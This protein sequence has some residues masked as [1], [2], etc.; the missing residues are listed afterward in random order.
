MTRRS[1]LWSGALLCLLGILAM[2]VAATATG[3]APA[4][5]DQAPIDPGLKD[6]LWNIHVQHRLDTF[7]RN[8]EA[9]G[10]AVAAL[11]SYG[12]APSELSAILDA[13]SAR[14]GALSE[15]LEARDRAGLKDVNTDLLQLWKDYRQELRHLLRGA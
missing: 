8:V 13:I 15:A 4:G 10:D 5:L 7:D 2:P 12:Y 9:A 3:T 1:I 14:R 6:E 11:D